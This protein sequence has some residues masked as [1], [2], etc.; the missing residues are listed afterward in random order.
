MTW[1]EQSVVLWAEATATVG[2]ES[3]DMRALLG[4][5]Q[6]H[7]GLGGGPATQWDFMWSSG[8]RSQIPGNWVLENVS[9]EEELEHL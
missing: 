8:M 3:G 5:S 9:P 1:R 4:V 7:L 6:R 2:E